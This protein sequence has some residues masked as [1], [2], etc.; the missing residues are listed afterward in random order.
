[1]DGQTTAPTSVPAA[2]S[3]GSD[4]PGGRDGVVGVVVVDGFA[5]AVVEVVAGSVVLVVVPLP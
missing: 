1:M 2:T 5:F 3:D 4:Q